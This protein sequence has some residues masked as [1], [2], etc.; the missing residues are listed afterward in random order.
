M[1]SSTFPSFIELLKLFGFL[2]PTGK[3]PQ[4]TASGDDA[5][6][7]STTPSTPVDSSKG[8]GTSLPLKTAAAGGSKESDAG[9][10]GNRALVVGAL[11]KL[12]V[13][14]KSSP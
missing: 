2:S 4:T 14:K 1:Q 12:F 11:P 7:G 3:M 6:V 9:D 13:A 5:G 10:N 8:T